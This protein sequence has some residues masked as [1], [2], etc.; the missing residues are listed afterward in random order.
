MNL[1]VVEEDKNSIKIEFK[2][3]T[4]T[5]TNLLERAVWEEGG[6]AAAVREHPFMKEPTIVVNGSNPKKILEK[7]AT[8]IIEK[9]DELKEEFSRAM[10]K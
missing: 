1:S 5:F 8:A 3:D 2:G 9:C 6:E 10:K 4:N 7:S